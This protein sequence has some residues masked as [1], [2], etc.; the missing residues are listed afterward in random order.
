MC[1][2]RIS[3]ILIRHPELLEELGE[4]DP[5]LIALLQEH[6]YQLIIIWDSHR[7]DRELDDSELNRARIL[8]SK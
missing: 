1:L 7:P 8:L 6:F 3:T 4:D 5:E 2:S